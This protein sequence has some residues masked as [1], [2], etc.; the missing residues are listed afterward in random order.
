MDDEKIYGF[1]RVPMRQAG[2]QNV[3]HLFA[4]DREPEMTPQGGP[5]KRGASV[6]GPIVPMRINYDWS[7]SVPIMVRAMLASDDTLFV[8][9]PP[10]L[11]DEDEVYALYGQED[12]QSKMAEH[13]DAFEGRKGGL[14]MAVSKA[15]GSR[16]SAYRMPSAP[17]FDGMIAAGGQ[18]YVS[19]VDGKVV[20]LGA[21]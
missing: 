18:V 4:C 3:Y 20:C 10:Q 16:R 8:A 19:T 9:G 17:V 14:L 11:A 12:M 2:T 6:Y 5:R 21:K 15:D 7:H 1:G 13:V